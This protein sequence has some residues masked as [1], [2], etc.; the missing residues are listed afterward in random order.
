MNYLER[1]MAFVGWLSFS[2][3]RWVTFAERH[4]VG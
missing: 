4:G 3:R 1:K 2:E